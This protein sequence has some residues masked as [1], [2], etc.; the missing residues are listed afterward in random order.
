ML[1]PLALSGRGRRLREEACARLVEAGLSEHAGG[2]PAAGL[3]YGLRKRVEVVRALMARPRLLLLDEPCA[4]LNTQERG[5]LLE[6][7]H[8]VAAGGVT[9]LVVEHDMHFVG[10]L[11]NAPAC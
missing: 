3:A 10:G 7:L 6:E 8:R 9:L 4:G 5:A 11:A 2:A 1:L